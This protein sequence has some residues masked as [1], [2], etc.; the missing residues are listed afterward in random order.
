MNGN[1][2]VSAE[3][4]LTESADKSG[5]EGNEN[6]RNIYGGGGDTCR[7]R[8]RIYV[9]FVARYRID[10]NCGRASDDYHDSSLGVSSC[11]LRHVCPSFPSIMVR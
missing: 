7:A 6:E 2:T 3:W 10:R 8:V 4:M 9:L 11:Q 5:S 1:A